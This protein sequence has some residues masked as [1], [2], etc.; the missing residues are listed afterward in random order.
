MFILSSFT[1]L[2]LGFHVKVV[3]VNKRIQKKIAGANF[4][5]LSKR[6]GT[7]QEQARNRPGKDQGSTTKKHKIQNNFLKQVFETCALVRTTV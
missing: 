6:P 4:L 2:Q 1:V 7:G 3:S 5:R